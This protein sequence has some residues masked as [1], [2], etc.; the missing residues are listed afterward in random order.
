MA[1]R[2][3]RTNFVR[4]S[5]EYPNLFNLDFFKSTKQ[6]KPN[7]AIQWVV[8]LLNPNLLTR[9]GTEFCDTN[10]ATENGARIQPGINS[11][12]AMY[13]KKVNL[14]NHP[15]VERANKHLKSCPTNLQAEVL[16]EGKLSFVEVLAIVVH[17]EQTQS[18][19][20]Q[21]ITS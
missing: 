5:I 4:C 2:E 15:P 6:P 3:G 10:A 20:Q 12:K 14:P 16:L 18:H 11:F 7:S 19:A 1:N 17:D 8:L 13:K 21:M 9:P